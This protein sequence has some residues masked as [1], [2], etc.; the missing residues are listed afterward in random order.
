METAYITQL[1]SKGTPIMLFRFRGG[2]NESSEEYLEGDVWV[3]DN[4]LISVLRDLHN[5]QYKEIKETEATEIA[6]QLG[7]SI[8]D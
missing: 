2:D 5:P 3:Q 8:H 1:D 4:S 6:K 7:G